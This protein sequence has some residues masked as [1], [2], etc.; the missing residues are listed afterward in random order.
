M[1]A[2]IRSQQLL[3]CLVSRIFVIYT[4]RYSLVD[5]VDLIFLVNIFCSLVCWSSIKQHSFIIVKLRSP[6][7]FQIVGL[8]SLCQLSTV[9]PPGQQVTCSPGHQATRSATQVT[10]SP[11]YQPRSPGHHHRSPGHQPRSPPQITRSPTQ[12]TRSPTQVT[13]PPIQVTR[14][15]TQVTR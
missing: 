8:S 10:R 7:N 12:V 3:C 14:S 9:K 1:T 11:G 13:R 4:Q 6:A 2:L 5:L 15:P